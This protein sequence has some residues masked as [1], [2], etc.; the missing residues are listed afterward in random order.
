[1]K[2]YLRAAAIT[3]AA[4]LTAGMMAGCNN[5][6]AQSAASATGSAAAG[7]KETVTL[8]WW[9]IGAQPSNLQ[10]GLDQMNAYTE[11]KIGVKVDI[12]MAGW[13]AYANKI[14]TIVGSGEKYDMMF[15]DGTNY[16]RFVN[17]GAYADITDTVGKEAP[18][19]Q[20]LVPQQ[21]WD[22][23]KIKDKIYAVPTY[24]DSSMTN[25]FAWDDTY[26][27]KY[28]IDYKNIKTTA[29]LDEPFHKMKQ[30]EGKTF[31]PL[32]GGKGSGFVSLIYPGYDDLAAGLPP[33]GVKIDDS[34]RKVLSVLEQ[35]EV[36]ANLKMLHKWYQDGIINPDVA[37]VAEAPKKS[38]FISAQAFPG[39]EA[40][41]QSKEGVKKYVMTQQT[42]PLY[43]T[44]TIQGS[45]NA[46]S[47]NSAHKA[48][49][50]K[51]LQLV[52]TDRYLRDM[53]AY[54]VE[55][56]DWKY[57]DSNKNTVTVAED[58]K[59]DMPAY[60]QGTFFIMSPIS[61]NPANQYD[62]VKE[63]NEKAKSSTCLGFA[64]DISKVS[65]ELVNCK[66]VW[67]KYMSE[68]CN[69]VSDPEKVVPQLMTQLKQNG[70]EKIMTEAQKQLD[71][72]A[73]A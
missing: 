20:K 10:Q 25:Y 26:V 71:A 46:I 68:L 48:E 40:S 53:L 16:N 57:T 73:K 22:G 2:K 54:G 18:E 3:C 43:T 21:V 33:L 64:L 61:P 49:C 37:T 56:K 67:E 55:G 52:N 32:H 70:F 31:Y 6:N 66:A 47:A 5:N 11:K 19:L 15:V 30:G 13:D 17:M 9:T 1:M 35:P 44:S 4:A 39:A 51:Y 24:K 69:G 7:N 65:T 12:K 36:M 27:Q 14:N 72:F 38:P 41:W 50:L 63:L 8:T 29:Q 42:E 58:K 62:S 60:T 28:S 34:S 23:V 45:L 59:W